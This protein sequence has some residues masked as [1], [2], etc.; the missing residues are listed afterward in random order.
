MHLRLG[1]MILGNAVNC[2]L[3]ESDKGAV[4]EHG[5]VARAIGRVNQ[6]LE[7]FAEYLNYIEFTCSIHLS[8]GEASDV[9]VATEAS[10]Y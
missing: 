5:R 8:R 9:F 1:S 6:C 7:P 4:L 3:S 10:W 2:A